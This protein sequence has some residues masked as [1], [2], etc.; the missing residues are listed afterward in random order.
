MDITAVIA[1][2]AAVSG[3]VLGWMGGAR[4]FKQEVAQEA[5]ADASLHTDVSY[6]KRG[7]DNIQ[8][9]L[10]LQGQRMDGLSERITRLE[11]SSKQAHK[12]LDRLEE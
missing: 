9:D 3:I 11:E 5:G 1:L 7:I 12:R 4:A 6:I 8:V 10:R 2:L